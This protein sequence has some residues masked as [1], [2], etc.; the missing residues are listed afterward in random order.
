MVLSSF[1][2]A[3]ARLVITLLAAALLVALPGSAP[4]KERT[5][6]TVIVVDGE[7][8]PVS[9]ASVVIS[10]LKGKKLNKVKGR[11]LQLKTSLEGT[12]PLPPLE[13]GHYMLQVISSGYQTH[14]DTI[15]LTE[16]EQLHEVT[17]R[18]PQE[19]FS[20]HTDENP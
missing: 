1:N 8:E 20:V 14:G 10:K 5:E 13:R 17:L 4:A 19:Q 15:E 11:P 18:P 6:L 9:R 7:G 12:A 3:R 2:T 16:A